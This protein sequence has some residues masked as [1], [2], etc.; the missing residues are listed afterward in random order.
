MR[1]KAR[2]PAVS[3]AAGH[4]E[5]FFLRAT[6]PGGGQG[7]WIRH[8]IHKRPGEE[9][10][11]SLWMTFFDAT[12]DA[13]VAAK[14][15][16][17][18]AELSFPEDGYIRIADSVLE[19]GLARGSVDGGA[20]Q[21]AWDLT[22]PD[23]SPA[24]RHLPS[25]LLYRS[26]L[27]RTK[28]MSPYPTTRFFGTITV[29]GTEIDVQGWPGMVGHNWG[30][31]HAERWIWINAID[32]DE[33]AAHLDIAAGRIVIG[34]RTTPWI[35][36][37][38]VDL[39]GVRHRL[40]GVL[41]IRGPS[42]TETATGCEFSI[43]GK[44]IVVRGQIASVPSSVVGWIYSDP[45]GD[46]HDVLNGS[47]ADLDVTVERGG[48]A[49]RLTATG[50]AAY[51]IGLREKGHGVV[52]QPY[53]DGSPTSRSGPV[54]GF[55]G[56]SR[57]TTDETLAADG[58]P[59]LVRHWPAVGD[60]WASVLLV[61]GL[62]EHSGRYERTGGLLAAAGI[63]VTAFDLRGNG[64]SG[65][66][67]GDVARWDDFLDDVGMMLADVRAGA[68]LRPVALFG[69]SLGGL[70][71]T[72]YVLSRRPPP[73]LL[74]LSA[75]GLDDGLPRW[76]HRVA[77]IGARIVPRLALKQA[78]GPEVLSRDPEVGRLA[79]AD[80]AS[81]DRATVRLGA[82]GF[83]AQ[84]RVRTNLGGLALRTLVFHGGDDT[85]VPTAASA[86][87]EG[88]PGVTRRVYPGLRHETLNEPEGPEVV[89]DVVEWLRGATG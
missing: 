22:F 72:D 31:Q 74:V 44:G 64:G 83:K 1:T 19:P 32:L 79:G 86:A 82:L 85:L 27:P 65:G 46:E 78:W 66:R 58:T 68:G 42:F 36:N 5:S 71:C 45:A 6:R 60:S 17:P 77:P 34:G 81:P 51:E 76:Q 29:G 16:L 21:A 53:P 75:P 73:D 39:E 59:L 88:M 50:S 62:G 56:L 33:A 14:S 89:A 3:P 49:R 28:V 2:Y 67:R 69:H 63:D 26:P 55:D 8:T 38:F 48:K 47:I 24:F 7:I 37:G 41:Q 18:A 40:G 70:V 11:A 12:A 52:V 61:H 35:A 80:P 13:P 20:V 30:S 15:T 57:S 84:E 10:T 9:A 87:F 54:P 25:P 43:R 23:G 4:Y